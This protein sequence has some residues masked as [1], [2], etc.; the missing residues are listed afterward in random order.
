MIQE[1]EAIMLL[2]GFGGLVFILANRLQL[3]RLPASGILIAG[4]YVLLA[5]WILTILEG[6]FWG[7]FLNII[8]HICYA[9][10]TALLAAWSWRVFGKEEGT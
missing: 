1:N 5:G 3:K 10:S 9:G 7:E 4:Y 6:L 8:E 2:L